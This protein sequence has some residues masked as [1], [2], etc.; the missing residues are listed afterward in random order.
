VR[1]L[2]A[3]AV[4]GALAAAAFANSLSGALVWDDTLLIE[5]NHAFLSLD[6]LFDAWSQPFW[7]PAGDS[8]KTMTGAA[9][10][11]PLVHTLLYAMHQL[12]GSKP[13]PFHALVFTGHLLTS[14][15]VAALAMNLFKRPEA[16]VISGALFAVHPIHTEAV[17]W[18]SGISDV[19][20]TLFVLLALVLGTAERPFTAGRMVLTTASLLAAALMKEPGM[21][22]GPLL[23]LCPMRPG[24]GARR[25]GAVVISL[26]LWG[27]LR[28]NALHGVDAPTTHAW[29]GVSGW[30]LTGVGLFGQAVTA[31]VAPLGLNAFHLLRAIETPL[32]ASFFGGAMLALG[33][34]AC[35]VWAFRTRSPLRVPLSLMG[36]AL[37]PGTLVPRLGLN[38]FA[39]R[40][41]YLP[42]V[43]LVLVCG[44]GVLWAAE[45]WPKTRGA[46]WGLVLVTVALGLGATVERNRVWASDLTLFSDIAEK[47][48]G[49]PILRENLSNALLSAGRPAEALSLLSTGPAL[50]VREQLNLGVAQA[51]TKQWPLAATTFEA[52]LGALGSGNAITEGLLLTNLCLVQQNLKQLEAALSNCGRAI[53]RVPFIAQTRAIHSRVL[54]LSGRREEARLEAARALM[55]DPANVPAQK[56]VERLRP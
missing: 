50:S 37:L 19:G 8:L 28:L 6:A 44:A 10:Y 13:W 14:V 43:G 46:L 41:L 39:E 45:R 33:L 56:M 3:L 30:V 24:E 47:S 5:H 42:S 25:V 36:L 32:S 52:A 34:L 26:G 16:A 11:R 9:Y 18:V 35:V 1:K 4:P 51:A 2:I 15:L 17:A 55:L 12:V 53:E 48:P 40:Y 20:M 22:A 49:C 23:L 29:L 21:L 31:L 38:P 7:G 54:M 27:A